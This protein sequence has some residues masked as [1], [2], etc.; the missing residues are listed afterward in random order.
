MLIGSRHQIR[1]A[2]PLSLFVDGS[3]LET[4]SNWDHPFDPNST[5]MSRF[6]VDKYKIVQVPMM[7]KE[8]K[9]STAEDSELRARILRLPYRGGAALLIVLPDATADYTVIDDEINA[10]RFL[11]WIK[12]MRRT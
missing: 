5:E 9:F 8:D 7:F 1:K 3:V 10:E 4:H 12:N 11:G 6:Y 2:A